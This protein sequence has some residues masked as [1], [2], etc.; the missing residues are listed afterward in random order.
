MAYMQVNPRHPEA[1]P[2]QKPHDFSGNE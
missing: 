2:F 1:R